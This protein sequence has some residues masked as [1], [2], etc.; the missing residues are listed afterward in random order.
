MDAIDYNF[1]L[2]PC[3][4]KGDFVVSK[5]KYYHDGLEKLWHSS[6]WLNPP[7]GQ[8]RLQI[9][10][11]LERFIE[12]GNGIAIVPNRTAT[13]WWQE[14]ASQCDFLIFVQGK[15]KFVKNGVEGKSPGYG[16]VI[17]SIGKCTK[18]L[19]RAKLEGLKINI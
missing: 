1:S 14:W 6:V 19:K 13:D 18:I 7:F 11:W 2:D 10:P 16:N 5:N 4:G 9:Q 15:V 12:H 8:K 17:G 3:A